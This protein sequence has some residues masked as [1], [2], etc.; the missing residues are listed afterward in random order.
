MLAALRTKIPALGEV[1]PEGEGRLGVVGQLTQALGLNLRSEPT[2]LMLDRASQDAFQTSYVDLEPF[3]KDIVRLEDSIHA[4]LVERQQTGVDR[5]QP[6]ASYFSQI[7]KLD[8]EEQAALDGLVVL[9]A[10]G[11]FDDRALTNKYFEN[12]AEFANRRDQVSRDFAPEFKERNVDDADLNKQALNE[13]HQLFEKATVSNNFVSAKFNKLL[14]ELELRLTPNQID[15]I[16][17]NTHRR[18]VPKQ[19]MN[20]LARTARPTWS[21]IWASQKA[22]IAFL[23]AY[24]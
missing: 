13:Y 5:N 1:L 17:R 21:R 23:E 15:Y 9:R 12:S 3:M 14:S 8:A 10:Q 16:K 19:V 18:A 6:F 2:G 20:I 24:Q 4:E 11:V 7:E 22:R